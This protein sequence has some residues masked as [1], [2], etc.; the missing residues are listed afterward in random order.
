MLKREKS[1]IR[2]SLGKP[3]FDRMVMADALRWQ[4]EAKTKT[5]KEPAM[6]K[7]AESIPGREAAGAKVLR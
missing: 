4:Q 6:E 1:S 7:L 3:S 5:E 2:E